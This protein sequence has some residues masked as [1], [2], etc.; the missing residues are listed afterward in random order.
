MA[1]PRMATLPAAALT[2]NRI[3]W[4]M[5]FRFLCTATRRDEIGNGTEDAPRP[6]IV[7]QLLWTG[8]GRDPGQDFRLMEAGRGLNHCWTVEA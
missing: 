1:R 8:E 2:V 5:G 4:L 3:V 6:R 7:A